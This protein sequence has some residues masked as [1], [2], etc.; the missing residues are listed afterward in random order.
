MFF[1]LGCFIELSHNLISYSLLT[2]FIQIMKSYWTLKVR[3]RQCPTH[4]ISIYILCVCMYVRICRYT[5]I[6]IREYE[7]LNSI[8][9]PW[10]YIHSC[11]YRGLD[12]FLWACSFM[13]NFQCM[14]WEWAIMFLF[15]PLTHNLFES[16]NNSQR[17][18]ISML[19]DSR[20]CLWDI[21]PSVCLTSIASF[22]L[23]PIRSVDLK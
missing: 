15:A 7:Y 2:H 13:C 22:S 19:P 20:L 10:L 16:V 21:L 3:T 9:I 5:Y 6:C 11:S 17:L 1:T 14:L 23:I 8:K 4:F 18:F 12:C